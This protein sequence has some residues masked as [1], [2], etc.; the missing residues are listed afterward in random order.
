[1]PTSNDRILHEVRYLMKHR[2]DHLSADAVLENI[3]RA[4]DGEIFDPEVRRADVLRR[5]VNSHDPQH[6]HQ[7]LAAALDVAL[8]EDPSPRQRKHA[9]EILGTIDMDREVH[10][11]EM[12]AALEQI[13]K[14]LGGRVLGTV[15]R[16]HIEAGTSMSGPSEI[17]TDSQR[18][19]R[20]DLTLKDLGWPAK[21]LH[22]LYLEDAAP[23]DPALETRLEEAIETW[24]A[25]ITRC[26]EHA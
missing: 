24:Q 10:N 20:L 16:F 8:G 1:M 6:M 26:D 13:S 23:E 11:S 5:R 14:H 18:L 21:I 17:I 7:D 25:L 3:A 19:S 22:P 9:E 12:H 15:L 4:L 2:T